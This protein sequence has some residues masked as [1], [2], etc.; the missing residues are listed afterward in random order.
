MSFGGSS[1]IYVITS[2]FNNDSRIDLAVSN[3]GNGTV[4]VLLGN[5]NGTFGAATHI[6]VPDISPVGI[7]AGDFNNDGNNDLVVPNYGNSSILGLLLGNGNGS[8]ASSITI[9]TLSGYGMGMAAADFNYDGQLDLVVVARRRR[10]HRS[11]AE[12][13]N[14]ILGTVGLRQWTRL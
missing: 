12:S 8:F 4:S 2:D 1:N 13:V 3:L 11:Y 14:P 5:G 10:R 9:Q 7:I 6:T